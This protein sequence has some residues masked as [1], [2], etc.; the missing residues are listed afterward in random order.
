MGF[1]EVFDVHWIFPLFIL[2]IYM[3]TELHLHV[4][5]C[6][7]ILECYN[8]FSGDKLGIRLFCFIYKETPKQYVFLPAD[9]VAN[10][11]IVFCKRYCLEVICKELGLWQGVGLTSFLKTSWE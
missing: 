6:G 8:L 5:S 7:S 9:K 11:I 2:L 1:V 3:G 4:Y 10:H